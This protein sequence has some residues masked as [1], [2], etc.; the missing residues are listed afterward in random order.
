MKNWKE[1]LQWIALVNPNAERSFSI[2]TFLRQQRSTSDIADL[3]HQVE[4]KIMK[5]IACYQQHKQEHRH[6][7]LD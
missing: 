3:V 6:E 1:F 7:Y 5:L 4:G 2:G